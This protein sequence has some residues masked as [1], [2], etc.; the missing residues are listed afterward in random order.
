MFPAGNPLSVDLVVALGKK[1]KSRLRP[2]IPVDGSLYSDRLKVMQFLFCTPSRVVWLGGSSL[3][4]LGELPFPHSKRP[5]TNPK[6]AFERGE[7]ESDDFP[8]QFRAGWLDATIFGL[9]RCLVLMANPLL[10]SARS[11]RTPPPIGIVVRGV[12]LCAVGMLSQLVFMSSTKIM[13]KF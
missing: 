13:N 10:S 7:E 2:E 8:A 6:R 3:G 4:S 12:A 1:V 9:L 5:T 11:S